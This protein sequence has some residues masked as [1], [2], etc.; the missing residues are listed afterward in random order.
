MATS[1]P[2]AGLRFEMSQAEALDAAPVPDHTRN[3]AVASQL[4]HDPEENAEITRQDELLKT[5]KF[6]SNRTHGVR[7]VEPG[8]ATNPLT[9]KPKA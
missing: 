2:F 8:A 4:R 5:H 9:L 6:Q 1:S 7:L 3:V